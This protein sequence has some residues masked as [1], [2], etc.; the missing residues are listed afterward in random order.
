MMVGKLE[1]QHSENSIRDSWENE[2]YS[3]TKAPNSS[4]KR[5]VRFAEGAFASCDSLRDSRFP[6]EGYKYPLPL[7]PTLNQLKP[8]RSL[9]QK[10][11]S[12]VSLPVVYRNL[13]LRNSACKFSSVTGV[14]LC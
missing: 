7:L 6:P 10:L 5:S 3:I 12:S 11:P 4:M 8:Q 14:I 9:L 13:S 2:R 1:Q